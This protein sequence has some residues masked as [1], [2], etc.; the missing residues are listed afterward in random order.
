MGQQQQLLGI[1]CGYRSEEVG[2]LR[3]WPSK[4]TCSASSSS[5]HFPSSATESS[6]NMKFDNPDPCQV[7]QPV[8]LPF[9]VLPTFPPPR[10]FVSSPDTDIFLFLCP[11]HA[12]RTLPAK[13]ISISN[14]CRS[15]LKRYAV[16]EA[17]CFQMCSRI[18]SRWPE[19]LGVGLYTNLLLRSTGKLRKAA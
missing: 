13:S 19:L 16:T 7:S 2:L 6:T 12:K 5:S 4:S 11:T 3:V 1:V 8:R 17:C 18:V 9:S 15:T 14:V 10:I